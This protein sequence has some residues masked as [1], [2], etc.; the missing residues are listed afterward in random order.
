MVPLWMAAADVALHCCFRCCRAISQLVR[1]P[2][3]GEPP[4]KPPPAWQEYN[5]ATM[6][7]LGPTGVD[8]DEA[9][10]SRMIREQLTGKLLASSGLPMGAALPPL[11]ILPAGGSKG[12]GGRGRG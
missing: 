4:I 9:E 7:E 12:K 3:E 10:Q 2:G 5:E 8:L 6:V 1:A 11:P